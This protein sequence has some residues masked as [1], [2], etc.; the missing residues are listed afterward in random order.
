[1]SLIDFILNVAGLLLWLNWRAIP[2]AV[3]ARPGNSLAS[4]LRPADRPPPRVYYLAGLIALL[5]VRAV[6]YWQL[7]A[8]VEWIP[9]IPLGPVTVWFRSD[10]LGRMFLF[11]LFSFGVTLGFFYLCLLLLS[12]VHAQTTDTDPAQRL[13]RALLGS[14]DRWP[15]AMKLLL[16]LVF[17]ALVWCLLHP[18]MVK[19]RI[20]PPDVNSPWIV[21]AQGAVIGMAAYLVLKFFLVAV[22][23][24]HLLNSYVYLGE[25]PF[26][27][28]VNVTARDLLRPITWIPLQ[29]GKIDFAPAFA[30]VVVLVS[31]Q[32]SQQALTQLYQKLI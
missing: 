25:F 16:P 4:T 9:R 31:A 2:F 21:V 17:T 23:A 27:N 12:W 15:A 32:F 29:A 14:L 5:G 13:V 18:L 20:V 28:F 11:S 30:I 19:L 10:V 3:P 24:L 7:G 1:M 8:Q 26:W 22:L 6:V